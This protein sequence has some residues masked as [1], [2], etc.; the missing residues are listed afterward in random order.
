MDDLFPQNPVEL[1]WK[2]AGER[3]AP[4]IHLQ[5]LTLLESA[6]P[7]TPIRRV[8]FRRG[9]NIV[10]ADPRIATAKQ[11]GSRLAGH[12][13]GKSTFCRIIRWLLGENRF[14][15]A[16][17]QE[18]I[19]TQF[20][21]GLAALRLEINGIPWIVGRQFWDSREHWAL[22]GV[23]LEEALAGGTP[24][25]HS[26]PEFLEALEKVSISPLTRHAIPGSEDDL[27]WT[28]VLAWLSR[29][30]NC[31]LQT[32]E[33]WREA[34]SPVDRNIASKE[35]RHILMRL[36]LDLLDEREWQEMRTSAEL[37]AARTA[38]ASKRI[39][40]EANAYAACEP[41]H[42]LIGK[43]GKSL[44]GVLLISKAEAHV[45]KQKEQ[46]SVLKKQ[47]TSFDLPGMDLSF[48]ESLMAFAK[49]EQEAATSNQRLKHLARRLAERSA[50][51]IKE[52]QRRIDEKRGLPAGFCAKPRE[53]VKG[54]C[55]FYEEAPVQ[56]STHQAESVIARGRDDLQEELEAEQASHQS[57]QDQL[58]FLEE[59]HAANRVLLEESRLLAEEKRNEIARCS[60]ELTTANAI[61]SVAMRTSDALDANLAE[62]KELKGKI[63]KSNARQDAIR[64]DRWRDRNEFGDFFESVLRFL[65]GE[66]AHGHVQFDTKGM[67]DLTA[68]TRSPLSSAAIDA[69]TVIAFDLAAMFW[70]ASGRGHHPR[71]VIH[72]S[73]RVADMSLVPYEAIFEVAQKAE[74][75]GEGPP[76]FQ[77]IITTT[78]SP[79]DGLKDA[80]VILE[81]DAST[82]V[83]R[84]FKR[85]L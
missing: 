34:P 19:G 45:R 32:V 10:W 60:A 58:P 18:A 61:L 21:K 68:K 76:N 38:E 75:L 46:L 4:A 51:E 25:N 55:P 6:I 48:Q 30:Q 39:E 12:S 81:L 16:E 5:E 66:E 7:F 41:I 79:P 1:H 73:P 80:H 27:Q 2:P 69:L 63:R 44:T 54:V 9:L 59:R 11:G 82:P 36:V 42:S 37:E 70:S 74:T 33:A 28:D 35:A 49:K 31:A 26:L 67:F 40:L 52:A 56:F 71:L 13:A 23:S 57:L 14:G 20:T 29:D 83:G 53:E 50:D 15:K 62:V 84:L 64:R 85:D 72:D 65:M 78:Q 47:L 77:Y 3:P 22:K 8:P 43:Q 24:R 17:L